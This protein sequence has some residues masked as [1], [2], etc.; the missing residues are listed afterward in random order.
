M[1]GPWVLSLVGELR[2]HRPCGQKKTKQNR[3]NIVTNLI[4]VHIKKK[5]PSKIFF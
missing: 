5:R 2:S 1:L 4:L 3:S